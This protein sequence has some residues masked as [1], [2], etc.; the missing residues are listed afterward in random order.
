MMKSVA[1]DIRTLVPLSGRGNLSLP[2][3]NLTKSDENEDETHIYL[4]NNLTTAVPVSMTWTPGYL[5]SLTTSTNSLALLIRENEEYVKNVVPAMLFVCVLIVISFL[6]NGLV[7]YVFGCRFKTATQNSLIVCLACFDLLMTLI[8]MPTE[9]AD[10]RFHHLFSSEAACKLLRFITVFSTVASCFILLTITRDRH[11]RITRPLGKQMSVRSA[12]LWELASTVGSLCFSWP[13]LIFYGLRNTTTKVPGLTGFDCSYRDEFEDSILPLMYNCVLGVGFLAVIS[14]LAFLYFRIWKVAKGHISVII[15]R[16]PVSASGSSVG[17]IPQEENESSNPSSESRDEDENLGKETAGHAHTESMSLP[18]SSSSQVSFA[19]ETSSA[20]WSGHSADQV[21]KN[22]TPSESLCVL[23]PGSLKSHLQKSRSTKLQYRQHSKT[24]LAQ[25]PASYTVTKCLHKKVEFRKRARSL[26]NLSAGVVQQHHRKLSRV[27][28]YLSTP[29]KKIVSISHACLA[30]GFHARD[31]PRSS[32]HLIDSA[33]H[34]ESSSSD[35]S[36]SRSGRC[37]GHTQSRSATQAAHL[38]SCHQCGKNDGNRNE[39]RTINSKNECS[40]AD[41][42][43]ESLKCKSVEGS[44]DLTCWNVG[45]SEGKGCYTAPRSA[46]YS[47]LV[48][49]GEKKERNNLCNLIFSETKVWS[50]DTSMAQNTSFIENAGTDN[51]HKISTENKMHIMGGNNEKSELQQ[52]FQDYSPCCSC[53]RYNKLHRDVTPARDSVFTISY[54]DPCQISCAS[55][56][57]VAAGSQLPHLPEERSQVTASGNNPDIGQRSVKTVSTITF[58]D[59]EVL[60]DG[61]LDVHMKSHNGSSCHAPVS[62]QVSSLSVFC[63]TNSDSVPQSH[64]NTSSTSSA[65]CAYKVKDKRKATDTPAQ[66]LVRYRIKSV[67]DTGTS[68]RTSG[69]RLSKYL[70]KTTIIAFAISSVFVVSYLPYLVLMTV[71]G[72]NKNFDY[73]LQGASLCAYNIFVRFYFLNCAANPLLYGVL[74]KR[75]RDECK[76]LL[77]CLCSCRRKL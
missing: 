53:D 65:S 73:K 52:S 22:S 30:D 41:R 66:G 61:S 24:E 28:S 77:F 55:I 56:L 16:S 12:R 75:F 10:M 70:D 8:S 36:T 71:R 37:S 44:T 35:F 18:A 25:Q 5:D 32:R 51:G 26:G 43:T 72:F 76:R 74:N 46:I 11:R 67:G 47:N 23:H 50:K 20:R 33:S 29:M 13:N 1:S 54:P 63:G 69:S 45:M 48:N 14:A 40:E 9:I 4:A 21:R 6:G 42:K 27:R 57:S 58:M 62:L 19:D 49:D 3:V 17:D 59:N 15:N 68:H 31:S 60:A 7:I 39:R 64:E 38:H 34:S 2:S